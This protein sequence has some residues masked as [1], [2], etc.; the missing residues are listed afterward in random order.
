MN[1]LHTNNT[2]VLEYIPQC[3]VSHHVKCSPPWICTCVMTVSETD[4]LHPQVRMFTAVNIT[5]L[6]NKPFF[7]PVWESF[8]CVMSKTFY[9]TKSRHFLHIAWD[10]STVCDMSRKQC[11]KAPDKQIVAT[12]NYLMCSHWLR[13]FLLIQQNDSFATCYY[14]ITTT[15][16]ISLEL[17]IPWQ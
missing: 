9:P 12:C 14:F 13:K 17:S 4:P 11:F 15:D 2:W 7:I 16:I 5:C 10:H 6:I 1:K 3:W 8:F